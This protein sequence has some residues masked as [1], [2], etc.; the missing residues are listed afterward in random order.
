MGDLIEESVKRAMESVKPPEPPAA[1]QPEQPPVSDPDADYIASLGDEEKETLATAR[2]AEEKGLK[3]KGFSKQWIEFYKKVDAYQE[4]ARA[5]DPARTLDAK[6]ED[7][8]SFID[9]EK[10]DVDPPEWLRIEK[11]KL[12]D[13]A[14]SEA[15]SEMSVEY[16]QEMAE[17]KRQQKALQ[18][19]PLI[20]RNLTQLE[21]DFELQISSEQGPLAEIMTSIKELGP[22]EAEKKNP[23]FVPIVR[24]AVAQAM[25][26]ATEYMAITAEIKSY[27][28]KTDDNGNPNTH[29]WLNNFIKEQGVYFHEHGGDR[30]FRV[31]QN[32]ETQSFVPRHKFKQIAETNPSELPNYWTFGDQDVLA[33]LALNAKL[34]AQKKV[35][36]ILERLTAS[37]YQRPAPAPKPAEIP[38]TVTAPPVA[39]PQPTG[40]PRA[41]VSTAP[42][43]ANGDVPQP[44]V[45]SDVEINALGLQR[46]S[47]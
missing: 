43:P 10:P 44:G 34:D 14:K 6:D 7:F 29:L 18:V 27:E 38:G 17:I 45:L 32:G 39:E 41:G 12:K 42:G 11:A 4:K 30:R 31:G 25:N 3:P 35:T 2:F 13:E 33:M 21:S 26:A 9:S 19:A 16:K 1:K 28:P 46:R 5:A 47:R 8:Q 15:K 37:G 23:I 40:S 36:G 22:D 24:G 20:E